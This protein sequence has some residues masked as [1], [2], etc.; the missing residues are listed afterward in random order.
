MSIILKR[1][2]AFLLLICL[3][4]MIAGSCLAESD[5]DIKLIGGLQFWMDFQTAVRV[6]G[7]STETAAPRQQGI[8]NANGIGT[9]K[10]LKGNGTIGG[11]PATVYVYSDQSGKLVQVVY[12]FQEGTRTHNSKGD[13][14]TT[15]KETIFLNDYQQIEESLTTA[16]GEPRA[17]IDVDKL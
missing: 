8:L 11:Y 1:A 4:V 3:F 13:G 7:Y 16:Y 15:E 2:G 10:Y 14:V 17:H 5:N 9:S 6:S 12:Y